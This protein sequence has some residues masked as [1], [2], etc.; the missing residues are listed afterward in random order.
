M[1]LYHFVQDSKQVYRLT[2]SAFYILNSS[3]RIIDILNMAMN[4]KIHFHV[5]LEA[6]IRYDGIFLY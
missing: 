3:E 6:L 1:G 5:L 2:L 4:L